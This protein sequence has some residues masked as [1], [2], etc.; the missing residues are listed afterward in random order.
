M[1]LYLDRNPLLMFPQP[2]SLLPIRFMPQ[3]VDSSTQSKIWVSTSIARKD[4]SRNLLR[5]DI[6]LSTSADSDQEKIASDE[7][8]QV[9]KAGRFSIIFLGRMLTYRYSKET[10]ARKCRFPQ[11]WRRT[12]VRRQSIHLDENITAFHK[13]RWQFYAPI[14]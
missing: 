1:C 2:L 5:L 13:P 8:P 6:Q 11:L 10:P 7:Q 12:Q 4:C 3:K 9:K 14:T